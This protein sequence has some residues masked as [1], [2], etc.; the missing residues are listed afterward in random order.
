MRTIDPDEFDYDNPPTTQFQPK[1]DWD[2][3]LDRRIHILTPQ[4]DFTATHQSMAIYLRQVAAKRGLKVVV[5]KCPITES[6]MMR[7]YDATNG[8]KPQLPANALEQRD[9]EQHQSTLEPLF[10]PTCARPLL[11]ANDRYYNAC[12]DHRS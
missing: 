7:A 9:I 5:K 3:L 1:Y 8:A 10:C 12:K 2:T 6:L 4:E 11:S